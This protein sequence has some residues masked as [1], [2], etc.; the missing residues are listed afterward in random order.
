[1][2]GPWLNTANLI[3]LLRVLLAPPIV[4]MAL[5][6]PHHANNVSYNVLA[7]A[8]FMA[9]ALTD[10]FDGYYA[11]KNDTVT[12][13][14]IFLDPLAD[15]LLIL[16]VLTALW[17]T[18]LLPLWVLILVLVREV[19]VSVIRVIGARRG[20]SFPASWSGKAKMFSQVVAAGAL[21]IFPGSSGEQI[22][23]IIVYLMAFMTVYS[24]VDYVIRA[25]REIFRRV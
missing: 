3:T 13:L 24:G 15:K 17:Y 21:L 4:I 5:Y 6:A 16:P 18:G 10:K 22:V 20:L 14:G 25:R 9:A 1:L 19:M 8:I 7:G 12:N 11:R 2:S 23:R